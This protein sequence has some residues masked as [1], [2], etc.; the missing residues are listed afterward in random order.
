M[1]VYSAD[2]E[3]TVYEGQDHTEAWSSALVAL[4]SDNPLVFHSLAETLEYLDNQD[5][6]AVLYYHNLKFDGNFWLSYLITELKFKQG[7]ERLPDNTVK[8]KD[9][10]DLKEKELIYVISSMGQWYTITFK[11]HSHLYTLKDSLKLYHSN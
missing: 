8:F 10:K 1:K 5:E 2:L 6:D 3:T 9:R 7:L 4:D 11:Y